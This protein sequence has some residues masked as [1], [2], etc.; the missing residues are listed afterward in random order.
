M[1]Y[2][3]LADLMVTFGKQYPA[4]FDAT[5]GQDIRTCVLLFWVLILWSIM[6]PEKERIR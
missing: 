5:L 3:W 1:D 2:T 4:Y 6:H